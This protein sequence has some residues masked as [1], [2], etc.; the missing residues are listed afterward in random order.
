MTVRR[1]KTCSEACR[2][3]RTA[4]VRLTKGARPITDKHRAEVRRLHA[5]GMVLDQIALEVDLHR[6][7]IGRLVSKLRLPLRSASRLGQKHAK[8]SPNPA[9]VQ[10]PQ[11][12][13]RPPQHTSAPPILEADASGAQPGPCGVSPPTPLRA[14]ASPPSGARLFQPAV[15][16]HYHHCQYI[17]GDD[18]RTW[19]K[20]GAPVWWK[21]RAYC[22][23]H[24]RICHAGRV[25]LAEAA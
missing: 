22:E 4:H 11:S 23:A 15:F 16:A 19:T 17:P 5:T 8:G 2:L 24:H 3:Q 21:S 9:M 7:Q 10:Q 6:S 14:P 1:R 13:P 20:C 18:P 25:W 12:P